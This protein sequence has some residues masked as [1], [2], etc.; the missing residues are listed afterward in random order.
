MGAPSWISDPLCGCAKLIQIRTGSLWDLAGAHIKSGAP[1]GQ[2]VTHRFATRHRS[3]SCSPPAASSTTAPHH[4]HTWRPQPFRHA[5]GPRPP[6]GTR[7]GHG[8][9]GNI[10]RS[11]SMGV[12]TSTPASL[13]TCPLLQH[14]RGQG[15][16]TGSSWGGDRRRAACRPR[17]PP[18]PHTDGRE[19]LAP[20]HRAPHAH[21]PAHSHTHRTDPYLC[22]PRRRT[23]YS[24]TCRTR[25][26]LR[27]RQEEG[28]EEEEM[29]VDENP[30]CM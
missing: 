19:Y 27:A 7:T 11:G 18:P 15:P 17:S 6:S 2:G 25:Q 20:V 29:G 26:R 1:P 3:H 21:A 22:I 30:R 13:L 9:L 5:S 8:E 14:N 4:H 24:A 23:A 28:E 16:P 12:S 10:A